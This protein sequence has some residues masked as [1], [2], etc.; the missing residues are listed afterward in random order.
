[1]TCYRWLAVVHGAVTKGVEQAI[2]DSTPK[3]NCPR[4]YGVSTSQP[5]SEFKH[6]EEDAYIDPYDGEKKA[7]RQITWLIRKGDTLSTTKPKTGYV[8]ICRK[9]GVGENRVFSLEVVACEDDDVP[10]RQADIHA[11]MAFHYWKLMQ[12]TN[13]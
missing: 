6:F 10:Q 9:F 8:E 5:F 3:R 1:M 2:Q 4:H 7:G 11:G 12:N 13:N